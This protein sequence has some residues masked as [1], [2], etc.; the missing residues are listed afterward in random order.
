[1]QQDLTIATCLFNLFSLKIKSVRNYFFK[2]S[3]E[4]IEISR[5]NSPKGEDAKPP[6]YSA[7]TPR[8]RGYQRSVSAASV[9]D[10]R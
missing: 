6:A 7:T 5:A 2:V 9:A 3:T 8:Q 1:M 4:N 10:K